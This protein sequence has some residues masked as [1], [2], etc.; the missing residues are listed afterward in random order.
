MGNS[1]NGKKGFIRLNEEDK[2]TKRVCTYLTINEHMKYE[3]YLKENDLVSTSF[4][5]YNI[6]NL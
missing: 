6:V 4:L 5:R 1:E 2:R 3:K